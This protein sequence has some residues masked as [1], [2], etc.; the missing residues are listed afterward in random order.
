MLDLIPQTS[1]GPGLPRRG[2]RA[3]NRSPTPE[4]TISFDSHS[5]KQGWILTLANVY[6]YPGFL[7]LSRIRRKTYCY[8]YG[9]IRP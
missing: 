9:K 1:A 7:S 4:L 5:T 6:V 8:R 3:L 2:G